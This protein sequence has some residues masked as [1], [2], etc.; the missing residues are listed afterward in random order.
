MAFFITVFSL[1]SYANDGLGLSQTKAAALQSILSAGQML[2]R[3]LVGLGLDFAGRINTTIVIHLLS[4]LSCFAFWL[5]S[6]SFAL[7]IVFAISIGALG[8]TVWGATPPI[9]QSVVGTQHLASALGVYWVIVSAPACFA[10]PI[11]IALL[12]RL[13]GDSP[14]RTPQTY[15]ASIAL[16]GS[17]YVLAGVVAI[18]AKHYVQG[19][20]KVMQKS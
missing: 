11:A 18:G 3:P 12:D 7:L 10:N 6:R 14:V 17:F 15:Q 2:G 16:C 4:G 20:W 19:N 9:A 5:P 1:A 13:Q 8:G